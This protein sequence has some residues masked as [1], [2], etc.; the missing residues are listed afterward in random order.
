MK[1][2]SWEFSVN[3]YEIGHRPREYVIG[4]LNGF[5]FVD[6]KR[7]WVRDHDAVNNVSGTQPNGTGTSKAVSKTKEVQGSR[8]NGGCTQH[9]P[10]NSDLGV[11]LLFFYF[12][13]E[14]FR[15]E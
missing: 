2:E 10:Y 14:L 13:E 3:K 7:S 4:Y 9:T 1:Q 5:H 12:F 15:T 8:E 6:V 11:F